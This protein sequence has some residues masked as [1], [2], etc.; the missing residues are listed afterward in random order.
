MKNKSF[1]HRVLAVVLSVAALATGQQALAET[2]TYTISGSSESN[3][4][5]NFAVTATGDATGTVSDQ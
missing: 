3:G 5:V 1:L 2:V 4:N